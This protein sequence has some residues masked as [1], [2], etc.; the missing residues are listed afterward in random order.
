MP[1]DAF[2]AQR[3]RWR[4]SQHGLPS[5]DTFAFGEHP[6]N[7]AAAIKDACSDHEVQNP[8]LV[9][10]RQL[11]RW[12]ILGTRKLLSRYENNVSA[13]E[14]S[15]IT[16]L[17]HAERLEDKATLQ[18]IRVKLVDGREV[19]AWGPPGAQFFAMWNI[20]LMLSRMSD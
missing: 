9:F 3:I 10:G 11:D 20:V 4:A 13:C 15:Q 2:I 16:E 17:G 5:D 12:T 6:A 19:R 7:L 1:D 8:V 14:Y 18:L